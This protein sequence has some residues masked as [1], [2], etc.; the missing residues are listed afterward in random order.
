MQ[1]KLAQIY[2]VP[3]LQS[4]VSMGIVLNLKHSWRPQIDLLPK[5]FTHSLYCFRFSDVSRRKPC[6]NHARRYFLFTF[7]LQ[8]HRLQV[9]HDPF[10]TYVWTSRRVSI[11]ISFMTGKSLTGCAFPNKESNQRLYNLL[12]SLNPHWNFL[13]KDF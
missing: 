12:A 2:L 10:I 13:E 8:H 1:A 4:A 3:F 7:K 11:S 6:I 5:Q 9:R